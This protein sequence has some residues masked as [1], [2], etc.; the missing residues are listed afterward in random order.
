MPK[1][2]VFKKNKM[3]SSCGDLFADAGLETNFDDDN[4]KP[5]FNSDNLVDDSCSVANSADIVGSNVFKDENPSKRVGG[6]E[7][8]G[9]PNVKE[10]SNLPSQDIEKFGN[11]ID[12]GDSGYSIDEKCYEERR[13]SRKRKGAGNSEKEC[14]V[15]RKSIDEPERNNRRF[16]EGNLKTSRTV[17][18]KRRENESTSGETLIGGEG[19]IKLADYPIGEFFETDRILSPRTIEFE[20]TSVDDEFSTWIVLGGKRYKVSKWS[21]VEGIYHQGLDSLFLVKHYKPCKSNK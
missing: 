21:V 20:K 1:L 7:R 4:V 15:S 10:K 17:K 6:S 14:E 3:K 9:S 16:N 13:C 11:T 8:K 5:H 2:T 12:E 19:K 18:N